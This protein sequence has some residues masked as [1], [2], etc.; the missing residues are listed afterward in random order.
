MK[1]LL[2]KDFL[3]MKNYKQVMLFMLI[4]GIFVG[5]NDISF[6]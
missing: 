5:M 6:A 2:I 4:I 3:L 1:G